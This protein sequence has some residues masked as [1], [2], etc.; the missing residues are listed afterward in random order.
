MHIPDGFLSAPV[1]ITG[2]LGLLGILLFALHRTRRTLAAHQ[3]PLMGILAACIFAAQMISFHV[4]D[5]TSSH[6]LGATLA[7]ILLDPWAA[8]LVM[9]SVIGVQCLL[10]HDG[11][12]L[13]LGFNVLNIGVVA[14]FVGHTTFVQVRKKLGNTSAAQLVGAG[15]GAWLGV[16]VAA[17]VC[18]LDLAISGTSPLAVALPEMM[19]IYALVGVGEAL[20]TVVV[21][22]FIRQTQ[23]NWLV[24]A[25]QASNLNA[26][27][28]TLG[29]MF[30]I[31]LAFISPL[32]D[33]SPDGLDT[34]AQH[35]GFSNLA[36]Q[37]PYTILSDYTVPFIQDQTLTTIVAALIGVAVT[38]GI[39]FGLATF[40]RHDRASQTER[41]G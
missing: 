17:A 6:L 29:L 23:P 9:A 10:F 24:H 25:A 4:T 20:I 31:V 32:A 36:V 1:S 28:I 22:I 3:V 35:L 16:V 21:L 40:S 13:A 12:L 7:A 11:G 5:G 30:A 37:A 19:S 15:V 8:V 38:G 39:A 33:R 18:A 26:D 34:V 2:W 41:A 14:G 27:W